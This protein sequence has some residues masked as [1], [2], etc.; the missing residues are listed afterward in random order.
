M[1]FVEGTHVSEACIASLFSIREIHEGKGFYCY[2]DGKAGGGAGTE[3]IGYD[4]S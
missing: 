2:W 3:P 1:R 4:E